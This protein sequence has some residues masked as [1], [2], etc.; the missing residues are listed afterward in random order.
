MDIKEKKSIIENLSR[1][2]GD[3]IIIDFD[4]IEHTLPANTS[5]ERF[6]EKLIKGYIL[7]TLKIFKKNDQNEYSLNESGDHFLKI[8]EIFFKDRVNKRKF[9]MFKDYPNFNSLRELKNEVTE[10]Y[11]SKE[12]LAIGTGSLNISYQIMFENNERNNTDFKDKEIATQV[13]EFL[14][15]ETEKISQDIE[16]FNQEHLVNDNKYKDSLK[17]LIKDKLDYKDEDE[18]KELWRKWNKPDNLEIDHDLLIISRKHLIPKKILLSQFDALKKEAENEIDEDN[19]NIFNSLNR[20]KMTGEGA[21]EDSRS[22]ISKD[23]FWKSGEYPLGSSAAIDWLKDSLLAEEDDKPRWVMLLGAA[24]NGK[25]HMVNLLQKRLK[26]NGSN[27]YKSNSDEEN[28]IDTYKIQESKKSFISVNDATAIGYEDLTEYLKE[29]Y[30]N[31]ENLLI[32]INKGVLVE[33]ASHLESEKKKNPENPKNLIEPL[34][35]WMLDPNDNEDNDFEIDDASNKKSKGYIWK[36]TYKREIEVIIVQMDYASLL[37]D[38]ADSHA[39]VSKANKLEL[40]SYE[41]NADNQSNKRIESLAGKYLLTMLER[42]DDIYTNNKDRHKLLDQDDD[43]SPFSSNIDYLK[44]NLETFLETV[45]SSEIAS[46]YNLT[47]RDLNHSFVLST[48]G[49]DTKSGL[50][51]RYEREENWFKKQKRD[52]KKGDFDAIKKLASKRVHMSIFYNN[53]NKIAQDTR[54]FINED[55]R[56]LNS[57]SLID[58]IYDSSKKEFK[59]INHALSAIT[60]GEKPSEIIIEKEPGFKDAWTAFDERLEQIIMKTIEELGSDKNSQIKDIRK[61]YGIYLYRLYGLYKGHTGYKGVI[62]IWKQLWDKSYKNQ[63]IDEDTEDALKT[64][65]FGDNESIYLPIIANRANPIHEDDVDKK[66]IAYKFRK[67]QFQF[68]WQ[69]EGEKLFAYINNNDDD[70]NIWIPMNFDLCK[71]ISLCNN[72]LQ[73]FSNSSI[74][75]FNRFER[76]RNSLLSDIYH[77]DINGGKKIQVA[78]TYNTQRN[79]LN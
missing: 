4:M 77:K 73:G 79:V 52:A 41:I 56:F 74:D 33:S 1:N 78:F 23:K 71:E 63:T 5:I 38:Y 3:R 26:D 60:L 53:N 72:N 64:I 15:H 21:A 34:I 27:P 19:I 29:Y 51:T 11:W 12:V 68:T 40:K 31:K 46:G 37:E 9:T 54:L 70:T 7:K 39:N 59:I 22:T 16:S 67:N 25:S 69:I 55:D 48:I 30:E 66:Q 50:N 6:E 61:W 43:Y 58:P 76:F 14:L 45:R 13:L 47:Y 2:M 57:A 20:K 62:E 36:I 18:N 8:M 44:K 10:E 75:I 65:L 32:A 49:H 28:G 35:K 24:G 42:I 17:K